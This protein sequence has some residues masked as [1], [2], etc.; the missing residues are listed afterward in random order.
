LSLGHLLSLSGQGQQRSL[1]KLKSASG[2]QQGTN[3]TQRLPSAP[4]FTSLNPP[5]VT[6]PVTLLQD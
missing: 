1:L 3:E 5:S 2:L 4:A 6:V